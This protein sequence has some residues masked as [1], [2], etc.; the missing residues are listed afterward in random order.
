MDNERMYKT[1][2]EIDHLLSVLIVASPV[3]GEVYHLGSEVG[4]RGE[5]CSNQ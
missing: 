2:I 3:K 5:L 4:Q 1:G